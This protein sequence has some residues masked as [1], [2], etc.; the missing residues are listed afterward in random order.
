MDVIAL[1]QAGFERSG[2][3][4][5]HRAD[6]GAARAAV[7]DGRRADPVLRR[8]RRGAEGGDP[9][10][11][12]RACRML[13]ARP[14]PR[15]RDAARGHGPRRSGPHAR[16]PPRSR[17]CSQEPEPLVDRIWAHELA[18]EPLDTPEAKAGLKRRLT[19]L[20][21]D[22]RRRRSCAPN[23]SPSSA[24][25]STR[26]SRRRAANA[27]RAAAP[28]AAA[29][30]SP[31]S[32]PVGRC[33]RRQSARGGIDRVL[34]K[35]VLAGLIRHPAEIAR[36]MEVLGSLRLADGALG[37]LFEAVVD[38]ALEDRALDSAGDSLTILAKSGFGDVA[39]RAAPGGR[40]HRTRSPEPM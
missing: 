33:R 22:D 1:A 5:R 2:R 21:P 11:A 12:P 10:R 23:T 39:D 40:A 20:C 29:S 6:R 32:P 36:H 26:C 13:A 7:A 27:A 9:R 16:A 15:L 28:S 34:A 8:R 35:A 4:A 24:A 25:A 3:A 38:L 18:A 37:R 17:H 19:E 31:L 30:G 14:Q